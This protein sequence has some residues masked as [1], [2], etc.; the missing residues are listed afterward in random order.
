MMGEPVGA[1][2]QLPIA[3]G[4]VLADDGDRLGRALGLRRKQLG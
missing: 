2:L 4:L 1:S 3:Q